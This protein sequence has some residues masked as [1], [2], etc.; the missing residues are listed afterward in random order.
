M[1]TRLGVRGVR[2]SHL[3]T[4]GGS[5]HYR[6]GAAAYR[7]SGQLQCSDKMLAQ[8]PMFSEDWTGIRQVVCL[9]RDVCCLLPL[10]GL[11]AQQGVWA[12]PGVQRAAAAA[13]AQHRAADAMTRH[14]M[15]DSH[16]VEPRTP[17]D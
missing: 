13:A 7:P 12:W 15:T 8:R 4:P 2:G 5:I 3:Y 14:G 1:G 16:S 17:Q 11:K 9:V 10:L 6:I